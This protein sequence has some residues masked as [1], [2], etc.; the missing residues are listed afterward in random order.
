[1]GHDRS[2]FDTSAQIEKNNHQA[3]ERNICCMSASIEAN[4]TDRYTKKKIYVGKEVKNYVI[5]VDALH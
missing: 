2:E 3:L 5:M 1:L 4:A